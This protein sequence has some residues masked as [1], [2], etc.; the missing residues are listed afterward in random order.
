MRR[1]QRRSSRAARVPRLVVT[2]GTLYVFRGVDSR[3]GGGK[4]INAA[5]MPRPFLRIGTTS[6]LGVIPWLALFALVVVLIAGYGMRSFRSG[7][8]L[9]AI[10]SNPAAARAGRRARRAA[11]V[12]RVRRPAARWPAWPERCT[13]PGSAPST[14]RAA[15]ATS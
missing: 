15:S 9:Y 7:R 8:D 4:Q 3:L 5:D 12:R 2:L 1:D 6:I 11:R 10:G 14:P 13:S